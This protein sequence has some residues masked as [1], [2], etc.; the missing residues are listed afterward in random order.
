MQEVPLSTGEKGYVI[1]GGVIIT[2]ANP[3]D[4]IQLVDIE[5][6]RLVIWTPADVQQMLHGMRTPEGKTVHEVEFYLAGNVVIREKAGAESRTIFADEV[7]YDVGRNVA[8]AYQA[9]ME[10]V[11]PGLPQPIQVTADELLQLN[12]REFKA[13]RTEVF[14]SKLPSDPGLKIHVAESTIES[15]RVPRKTFFGFG[16]QLVDHR[17]GEPRYEE[18]MLFR[19]RNAFLEIDDV[20]V[21][22][23]PYIQGDPRD[24]LG[25]LDRFA[26]NYSN[27]FGFAVDFGLNVYDLF[28]LDPVP[29]TRW[30]FD[31]GY[32][33]KRGVNVG[34][35]Y[36]Y[37]GIDMFDL[38]GKYVGLVKAWGIDDTGT[39]LLGANRGKVG[40]P[41]GRGRVLF[42][43]YQEF[44]EDF[45]LWMQASLLSDKNFLEQ[46]YYN[47]FNSDINQET[48]IYLKQQR[49]NWAWTLIGEPRIRN[50]VNETER[51]PEASGYL[52]G[53]SFFDLL[54]YN[55]HASAGYDRL[56]T[57]H[58]PPPNLGFTNVNSN[59]GRFDFWQDLSAPFTLGPVRIVP[60]GVV[61]L[62]YYTEDLT[63][64]NR[65]RFY[66]GGGVR[67]S[68][69][70]SSLYP[71]VHSDLMNLN[72]INHKIV[73]SGNYY[74]AHSDTSFKNFAQF[75]RLQD[76]ASDQ[77]V[78]DMAQIWPGINTVTGPLLANS[79]VYD[80]QVYAI[81]RLV[82]NRVDT[83]DT[84]DVLQFDLRQRL[85]TKRGYPGLQHTV[86]WM[87]LDMSG[88][89]FPQPSRDNFGAPFAFLEYDYSWHL[90]DR[91][92][93][94][95][96]G[97]W[98]PDI[99]HGAHVWNIGA[100]MNR[101]DRTSFYVG[102]R[103]TDP[104][105]SQVMYFNVGYVFSP[106]YAITALTSYN[107]ATGQGMSNGFIFTRMGSDVQ[108]SFGFNYN[109]VLNNVSFLVG[110]VPNIAANKMRRG[111]M[112]SGMVGQ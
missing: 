106:K 35:D 78:R 85:Q 93:I 94:V 59:S 41:E 9:N 109:A 75:D 51:A 20:P 72:G 4:A 42:R 58:V 16:P 5:S 7:Y 50:W 80:P 60:Y 84:I 10:Y 6:D 83:L 12:A 88:S 53:Q 64:N 99:D 79:S 15:K 97:W 70:L 36:N 61:D 90:G 67:G 14:S 101:P 25:P 62:T 29:G 46:Y 18:E 39:D 110:I 65:G 63:G 2:I 56:M 44:P 82:D 77:S 11:Q 108:L 28:G 103:Q 47:E 100:F 3:N 22:Y 111:M 68:M 112:G 1:T 37:A 87:T 105:Q 92:T 69:P 24:P 54:T 98:D 32:M 89:F 52:I 102:Y 21:F 43:H 30:M 57:S 104:L 8:V 71:S 17:T 19:G 13:L 66:G 107:F 31:V 23:L 34:T 74:V 81:R 38:P 73:M 40:H 91:T 45:T 26:F 95:S 27:M 49:D 33:T 55:A 76:D 48:F 86:D 96:N